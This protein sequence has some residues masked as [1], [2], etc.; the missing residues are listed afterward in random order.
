MISGLGG[1][2]D[3]VNASLPFFAALNEDTY[4]MLGSSRP[5]P[6]SDMENY[7]GFSACGCTVTKNTKIH[8]KGRYIEPRLSQ[9]LDQDIL[10]FSRR[11]NGQTSVNQLRDA[12]WTA[13]A[14]YGLEHVIFVDGGGDSLILQPGDSGETSESDDPFDGG[15]AEVL[16][17]L[18]GMVNAYLAVVSVGLDVNEERFNENVELLREK[19]AYFGKVNLASGEKKDYALNNIIEFKP[20]F[21]EPYFAL[22]EEVLVL[23]ETDFGDANK[24]KS[25]TAVVTYH[26]LKGNF[27]LQRTYVDWE[28]AVDG[29]K[30]VIVKPKHCWMHFL[31]AGK[32]HELKK[33]L[34][35]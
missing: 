6:L 1:G 28:P 8:Y 31:D 7:H 27:G 29:E 22:A 5:A 13:R 20:G 34:N 19:D 10:F 18:D 32:V 25:H 33:E 14:M 2:L 4:A 9:V 11:C 15:D 26:A 17:A 30:G 16:A 12:I 23:N 3:I 24:M 35:L 21:L